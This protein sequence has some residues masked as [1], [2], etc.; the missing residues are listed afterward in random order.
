MYKQILIVLLSL[1]LCSGCSKVLDIDPENSLTFK[2]GLETPKDFEAA[3]RGAG[4]YLLDEVRYEQINQVMKGEYADDVL[5]SSWL[6]FRRNLA[7]ED[8]AAGW[9]NNHYNIIAQANLILKF[10]DAADMTGEQKD[11]YKG[12]A[13]FYKALAYF[14]LIRQYGDCVLVRDEVNIE[15]QAKTAWTEV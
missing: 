14:E 10:A 7:I 2:N 13:Y 1:G 8:I 5:N 3:L 4:Q 6:S 9:W 12:Q 15:P 11:L